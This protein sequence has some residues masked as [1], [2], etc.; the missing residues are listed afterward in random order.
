VLNNN[1]NNNNNNN[2]ISIVSY[3]RDFKG[4]GGGQSDSVCY[5]NAK[6]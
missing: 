3:G 6:C 5:S 2:H 1:N 4:A